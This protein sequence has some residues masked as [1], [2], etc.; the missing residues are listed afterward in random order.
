M[1]ERAGEDRGNQ[2]F[3]VRMLRPFPSRHTAKKRQGGS[4]PNWRPEKTVH[5]KRGARDAK[6]ETRRRQE[7]AVQWYN[8]NS[9]G[10]ANKERK[11]G[12]QPRNYTNAFRVAAN[13]KE[14]GRAKEMMSG[15]L[16]P[17]PRLPISELLS[18]LCVLAIS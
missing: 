10:Q 12:V 8:S 16:S 5:A 15:G 11:E 17:S 4:M 6:R 9:R 3:D 7:G 14:I 18:Q 1:H 2:T 13:R